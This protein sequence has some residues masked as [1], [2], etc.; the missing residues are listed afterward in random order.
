MVMFGTQP[1]TL[2]T[3]PPDFSFAFATIMPGEQ[4]SSLVHP[5]FSLSEQTERYVICFLLLS[6]GWDMTVPLSL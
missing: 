5:S 4:D 6:K 3:V 1:P 2:T